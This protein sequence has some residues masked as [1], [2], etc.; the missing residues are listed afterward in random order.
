MTGSKLN[1]FDLAPGKVLLDRFRILR[2]HR[3]AGMSAAFEVESTADGRKLELQVFL[4]NLFEDAAQAGEFAQRLE[5]WKAI[6]ASEV[7]KL[8]E[9]TLL[10]DG[11]LVYVSEF[12]SG[13]SLREVLAEGNTLSV[14]ATMALAT[15]LFAG[16]EEIHGAGLVHGDIKPESIYFDPEAGTAKLVD[17]GITP[18]M[19]AAK[20]LGT[21]TALIGTPFYAPLEQFTGDSPDDISDLYSVATVL[22]EAVAGVL[23]WSGQSFIE[24]FQSKMTKTPPAMSVRAPGARVPTDLERAIAKGMMGARAE[25]YGSVDEFREAFGALQLS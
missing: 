9:L 22:Y 8:L 21:R 15:S 5:P 6:E 1:L 18:G 14:D 13:K 3:Q 2:P 20:H 12:P 11:T 10:D 17:G 25:R 16:L 19:W 4:G 7:V 23:P 24:V